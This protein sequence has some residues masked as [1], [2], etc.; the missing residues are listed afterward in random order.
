MAR[1][2]IRSS[3]IASAS[4]RSTPSKVDLLFERFISAERNEPPDIDVDFEHERREEI[5]QYIYEKYGRDRAGLAATIICYRSRA[6]LRDVGQ[7]LGLSDDIINRLSK[8]IWGWS[9]EGLTEEQ[10][11]K[12]R[13][14]SHRPTAERW[15]STLAGELIGTP[16]HLSQHVGGFVI[17][18][19]PLSSLVPIENA[20]MEDRTVIQWDKDDLDAVG[21]AE[22]R[23]AGARHAELHPP[24]LRFHQAA[25]MAR[26]TTSPRSRKTM[27]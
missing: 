12:R 4:P 1:Q 5:I 20:A 17:S 6:A 7:A 13:P 14:R 11:R 8:T 9:D 21:S 24:R 26:T 3:A 27:P 18:K 15:P 16:R 25:S 23:C 10:I 22:G 19:G 2:P